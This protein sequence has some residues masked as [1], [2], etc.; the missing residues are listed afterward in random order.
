MLVFMSPYEKDITYIQRR[1]D[2]LRKLIEHHNYLYHVLNKPEISDSEFDQLFREL[3][4][5]ELKYPEIRSLDSPT[6]R[7]GGMPFKEFAKHRHEVTMLSLDNAF[8]EEELVIFHERMSRLLDETKIEYFTELKFDGISIALI[9]KNGVLETAATRGD[10]YTGEIVTENARTVRGIPLQ[11]ANIPTEIFE[12]R[13][14]V[15]MFKE[16]FEKLNAKRLQEGSALFV[17]PRNAASGSLRQLDSRI[18]ASRKLNF[19]SYDVAKIPLEFAKTQSEVMEKLAKLH[20][21]IS[22][23]RKICKGIKEILEFIHQIK[24]SRS[25]LPFGIDGVVIKVN[26][27]F[28]QERLGYT[29]RA[30]RWA[31]AYKFPA[32]Q[33]FTKLLKIIP[34]VGRT[35]VITPVAVLEPVFV[36]GVT[37]SRATLHNYEDLFKKDVREGDKVII[38]RAGDVIPEV[39]G[40]VINPER[41]RSPKP[42]IPEK[43]PECGTELIKESG[44]VAFKCP[45]PDC[46][47]QVHAKLKH[48][49]SR[50]AMDIE[51]LGNK[52]IERLLAL[53]YLTDIPSIYRLTKYQDDLIKLD[54]LGEQSVSNLLK[55]IELSKTKPVDRFIYALGIPFVGTRTARDLARQYKSV[56]ALI[57]A[58]Y[59]D[60]I[61]IQDIG[62]RTASE[63]EQWVEDPVNQSIIQSLFEHGVHPE[64]VQQA[65]KN[66]FEGKIIVFT[67]KLEQFTRED[68]EMIVEKLGG[69]TS[70]SVSQATSLIVAGPGAGSKLTKAKAFNIPV[71]S[72][73]EFI[74]M[75]PSNDFFNL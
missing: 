37:V 6:Q 25:D 47:A 32:E 56:E 44:F 52:L 31:I 74:L 75:L 43:C 69:K 26:S 15:V 51:G 42:L 59:E 19:F 4:E 27:L 3:I 35:G 48:F 5:I 70:S 53:N 45:N 9:Y 67:G 28:F 72:E 10:G 39:L 49:A 58:H 41:I 29:S 17:N 2:E 33:T 8:G 20:F 12:V 66:L 11:I 1:A 65:T 21:P 57:H 22:P 55:A 30:P 46:P 23:Y 13:G 24:E 62:P 18:T 54:R 50:D 7:I 40:P 38:Q 16:A 36:G 60:L 34:Q 61:Q 14:E 63:I 73:H 68:A 64:K 71:I